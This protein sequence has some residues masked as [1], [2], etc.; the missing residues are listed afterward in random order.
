MN[1]LEIPKPYTSQ[2]CEII[3]QFIQWYTQK[4]GNLST[5]KKTLKEVWNE[6]TTAFGKNKVETPPEKK[7]FGK[8]K[9]VSEASKVSGISVG[10]LAHALKV[11]GKIPASPESYKEAINFI[12]WYTKKYGENLSAVPIKIADVWKTY[13]FLKAYD[14][15]SV[16]PLTDSTDPTEEDYNVTAE[17]EELV[18]DVAKQDV[19]E[20]LEKV[21]K[22]P[23]KRTSLQETLWLK[24]KALKGWAQKV[25]ELERKLAEKNAAPE[26]MFVQ[27]LKELFGIPDLY[28]LMKTIKKL[29]G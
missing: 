7:Y 14:H 27:D 24:E 3:V 10:K 4:Y 6:F 21:L 16:E 19:L 20:N 17:E 22:P 26:S 23:V 13:C 18:R 9:S 15:P 8:I 28:V 2:D 29:K 11:M 5:A 12:N 25:K 1:A